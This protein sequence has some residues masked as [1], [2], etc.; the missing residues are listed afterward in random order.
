MSRRPGNFS[1]ILASTA[2]CA[3][4]QSGDSAEVAVPDAAVESTKW[5]P[6]SPSDEIAGHNLTYWA[7]EWVRWA[8]AATSCDVDPAYD[9]DGSLCAEYQDH[10]SP[11]FFM[12]SGDP[13]DKRTRC[14]V[15][16]GKPILVPLMGFYIDNAGRDI[17]LDESE[18]AE[19]ANLWFESMRDLQLRVDEQPI[20]DLERWSIRPV[21]SD[22]VLPPEPNV[23]S[24]IGQSGVTGKISPA[25]IGGAFV[26]LQAPEPGPH[27]LQYGGRVTSAQDDDIFALVTNTFV[28]K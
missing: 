7:E 17:P 19:E 5:L 11:V 23:Y 3:A 25:F 27:S 9:F 21:R 16:S 22:Y 28:V 8:N 20:A 26:M 18:L 24:C 4:C 13:M 1:L 14:V 10:E 6:Y 15:P 12:Q 2:L